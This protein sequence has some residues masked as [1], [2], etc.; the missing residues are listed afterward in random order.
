MQ[1]AEFNHTDFEKAQ[2][3]A[4]DEKLLV[5]FFLKT[6][7]DQAA[8]MKEGRPMFKEVEYISI[9]VPGNNS[10]GACRP[11]RQGDL[12][13]F[14]RH[15]AAFKNRTEAPIEGTPLAEWPLM[16][17]TLVEQLAFM[18][19]KTVEQLANLADTHA[20][21]IMGGQ[22]FKRKAQEY[23]EYSKGQKEIADKAE[24]K[25]ENEELKGTVASQGTLIETLTERLDKLEA[26]PEVT[27]PRK[28]ETKKSIPVC[29]CGKVCKTENGLKIHK[30]TC[31][32]K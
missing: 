13:R 18:N 20:T 16:T 24:L 17:R 5:K 27:E 11:A 28:V 4:L 8:T 1:T 22:N 31:K 9:M 7:P 32:K 19:V 23:L 25:A 30:R 29:G 2:Q 21:Q 15:Y 6:R 10:G 12:D 14:P 26:D 3:T